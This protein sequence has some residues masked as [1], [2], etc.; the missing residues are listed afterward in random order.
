METK[1][2]K[3]CGWSGSITQFLVLDESNFLAHLGDFIGDFK[4]EQVEAWRNSYHVLQQTLS[5]YQSEPWQLIF[6]YELPRE[7]GRRPDVLLLL[8]G[9]LLVIEFKMKGNP[10]SADYEQLSS[11]VRDFNHYHEAVAKYS[12]QVRGAL[13]LTYFKEEKMQ[14]N[15][16]KRLYITTG[17]G[18]GK[19][20]ALL[21][22]NAKGKL[23]D[24][25]EFLQ[26]SYDRL[27]TIVEGARAIMTHEPLPSIRKVNNTN[28][29]Q[30][31]ETLVSI[32]EEAKKTKTHHL[33]LLTGVP[34]AG[35]TLVGLQFSHMVEDAVYLSGN[36][37]L[38]D[39]LQ[40]ALGN[41]TFVQALKN[42]K[43][44]YLKHHVIPAENIFIFD[45]AQRAWDSKKMKKPFS[46]PDLMV[47]IA[48]D[49]KGWSVII[50]LIGE[51]QEIYEGEEG[52]LPL[53]NTAIKDGQW[54]VHSH[55]HLAGQ[56]PH[57]THHV[58][59]QHLNLNVSLRSHLALGLHTWVHHLLTGK[60]D[61]CTEETNQLKKIVLP[62]MF[63]EI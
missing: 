14:I 50:G 23:L 26:G 27:P 7:G 17:S 10:R 62:C 11:Y 40:D 25:D 8:P 16:E 60:I 46:E 12:L 61:E 13:V 2:G 51:G 47:K 54:T 45:E 63:L 48:Q 18:L 57:A 43:W 34:G 5:S 58:T 6:E 44:E 22:K 59:H 15:T 38:V 36:G 3:R 29:S 37:P 20:L 55:E 35:K 32:V 56:F 9:E 33:V 30:V 24:S 39:V 49:L 53:W 28:I 41:K 4:E 1:Q 31:L 19:F 21:K 42:F 52:G